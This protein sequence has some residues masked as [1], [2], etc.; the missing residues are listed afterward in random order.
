[1]S[2]VMHALAPGAIERD[3]NLVLRGLV[4]RPSVEEMRETVLRT[5]GSA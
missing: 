1:M 5:L 4:D 3:G 2:N